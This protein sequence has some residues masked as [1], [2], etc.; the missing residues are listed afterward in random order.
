MD[1]NVRTMFFVKPEGGLAEKMVQGTSARRPGDA[2]PLE[3]KWTQPVRSMKNHEKYRIRVS[4]T[5]RGLSSPCQMEFSLSDKNVSAAGH[6]GAVGRLPQAH[7]GVVGRKEAMAER[8]QSG[9]L[10]GDGQPAGQGA[11]LHDPAA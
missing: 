3:G 1:D 5:L 8:R 6:E 2:R 4:C 9:S 7:A 10:Q 11:V